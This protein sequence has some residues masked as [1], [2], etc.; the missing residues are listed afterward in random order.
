MIAKSTF[1]ISN[2]YKVEPKSEPKPPAPLAKILPISQKP[3]AKTKLPSPSAQQSQTTS[4]NHIS[5]QRKKHHSTKLQPSRAM[6]ADPTCNI[7]NTLQQKSPRFE[8]RT[9]VDSPLANVSYH[10]STADK[11]PR[12]VEV[13]SNSWHQ[14][15]NVLEQN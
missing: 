11:Y 13:P 14:C 9:Q 4:S 1:K 2:R 7:E 8:L 12:P 15:R 3:A 10:P 5:P 6:R